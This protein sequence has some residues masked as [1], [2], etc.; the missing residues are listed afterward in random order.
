MDKSNRP[1]KGI[2]ALAGGMEDELF[3]QGGYQWVRNIAINFDTINLPGQFLEE[4]ALKFSNNALQSRINRPIGL[5]KS[6]TSA[7]MSPVSY[8]Y[9]LLDLLVSHIKLTILSG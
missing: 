5:S 3:G 8:N 1:S 6:R 7:S 2:C 9:L 4:N